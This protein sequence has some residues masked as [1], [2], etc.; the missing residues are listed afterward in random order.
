MASEK[1]QYLAILDLRDQ[2]E[3]WESVSAAPRNRRIVNCKK[4]QKFPNLETLRQKL[5]YVSVIKLWAKH[6][7]LGMLFSP[8]FNSFSPLSASSPN[9]VP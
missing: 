8:F 4:L 7:F 9:A 1:D 3:M 6:I 5:F 2:F